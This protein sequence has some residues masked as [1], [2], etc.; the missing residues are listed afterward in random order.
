M[1]TSKRQRQK[2]GR[3]ARLE[4]A[5]AAQQRAKRNRTIRN[6]VGLI[7]G[8]VVVALLFATFGSKDDKTVAADGSS[9]TVSTPTTVGAP[10]A[11]TYGTGACPAA[12]GSSPQTLTFA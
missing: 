2:A 12:D 5:R 1:T 8:L 10:A 7:A 6:V 3:Q 11:F 9:T 4:A